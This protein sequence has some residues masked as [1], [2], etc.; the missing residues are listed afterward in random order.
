MDV[1]VTRS[2]PKKG[3][4]LLKK[5]HNVEI[6]PHN[7]VLSKS[8]IID[9]IKEKDGLLCLLT[10]TIDKEIIEAE[11]KLK[12][13]A[14]YAVGFNNI[15][16]KTASKKHIPVSNT[17]DVLTDTTAEMA[18]ALLLAVARRIVESDSFTRKGYFQGWDPML[19]HGLDIS[20]KTLG[21][22]GAGRIGTSFALKS[23]GFNMKILYTD[24]QKNLTIEKKINAKQV[25]MH[26]LLTESDFI[27][28]HVPLVDETYHL[29]GKNELK[30]MK[31]TAVLINT[32]RGPV[33]DENALINSLKTKEIFGAGLDVYEHE[34]SIPKE[35]M[36]L[37]NAVLQPHSASATV[38]TRTKM[39][40]I[41]AQNM[42]AGLKG[43][44]PSNCVNP[45][46]FNKS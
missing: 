36:K 14:N 11:P 46:I 29:I 31:K 8:E 23:K 17:P 34:P 22:I 35:L 5:Y 44:I 15:D 26:E 39:A 9:G 27:S 37:K 6:N 7:R 28:I 4:D 12:M 2:L 38:H 16:I 10:D 21:V 18:W 24:H 25:P 43:H 33:I 42:I 45:E 32:S 1:F 19:F 41:A 13:I 30:K 40:V 3:L 20:G